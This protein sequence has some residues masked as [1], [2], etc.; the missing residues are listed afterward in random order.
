MFHG[1]N[2]L[3]CAPMPQAPAPAGEKNGGQEDCTDE[4]IA[5]APT[6]S[7]FLAAG[8]CKRKRKSKSGSIEIASKR[9][10]SVASNVVSRSA[11]IVSRSASVT[12][13]SASIASRSAS[14]VPL[15]P[16][17]VPRSPS[18][19][20][21]LDEHFLNSGNAFQECRSASPSR[22]GTILDE[23]EAP[24]KF[25]HIRDLSPGWQEIMRMSRT[26]F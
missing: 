7:A 15:S 23:V 22:A 5:N 11:S 13:H 4:V 21:C 9:S 10:A 3:P 24:V 19:V 6:L 12:S 20:S 25:C 8:G 26:C 18:T 16:S 1:K 2:R 17:V 14:I